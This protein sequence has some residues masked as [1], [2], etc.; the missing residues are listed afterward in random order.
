MDAPIISIYDLLMKRHRQQKK[1]E[2]LQHKELFSGSARRQNN[3]TRTSANSLAEAKKTKLK[4]SRTKICVDLKDKQATKTS[5]NVI[6]ATHLTK[7]RTGILMPSLTKK[8]VLNQLIERMSASTKKPQVKPV[9]NESSGQGTSP[10]EDDSDGPIISIK[11]MKFKPK[12][13]KP[14]PASASSNS[15][16]RLALSPRNTNTMGTPK[17]KREKPIKSKA[18]S[19]S[20]AL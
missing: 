18:V 2:Q 17:L 7:K 8:E 16:R 14:L 19:N 11:K 4:T 15:R 20:K 1:D 9:N 6:T 5:S 10:A 13:L 12:N 3:P